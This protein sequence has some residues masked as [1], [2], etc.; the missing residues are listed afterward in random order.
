MWRNKIIGLLLL[1]A[2]LWSVPANTAARFWNPYIVSGAISGAGGVC[3]LVISPAITG[4]GLIAGTPVSVTGVTGATGCNVSATISAV[5]D[6][7]HI[8]LTGTTFGGV[9]VSG[10]CVGGGEWTT[11]NTSNWAGSS[12]ATC[13]S[14]GSSVPG[15]SDA[16]TLDANS[17]SGTIRPAATITNFQSLTSSAFTGTLDFNVNNPSF[18]MSA[19]PSWT[20]AATGVHTINMGSGTWTFS[21]TSGTAISISTGANLTLNA[22]TST[23]LLSATATATR[24]LTVAGTRTFN[25]FTVNNSVMN[26]FVISLSN[27]STTVFNN[28]TFTNVQFV[29]TAAAGTFTINGTWTWDGT[30]SKQGILYANGGVSTITVANANTLSY[31]AIN[32]VTK[33]GAGSITANNSFDAGGN[34]SVTINAPAGGGARCI[35]C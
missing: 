2:G 28:V 27:A 6:S 35:G 18:T 26:P 31:L 19:N 33:A 23:I 10:G 32:G 21:L 16:I 8:E 14:G 3:Q 29:L 12:T 25:N 15:T 22:N 20:D 9:Y 1:L 11:T 34:T 13:G 17:L 30:S 7:T 4:S 24:S 5:V